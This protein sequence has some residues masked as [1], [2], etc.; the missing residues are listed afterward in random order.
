MEKMAPFA[1]AFCEVVC[2][3][4]LL[5]TVVSM[6]RKSAIYVM[7]ISWRLMPIMRERLRPRTLVSY[8]LPEEVIDLTNE[9]DQEERADHSRAKFDKTEN[10]SCKELLVLSGNTHE[11]EVLR[12]ILEQLVTEIASWMHT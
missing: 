7:A 3:I 12:S 8:R 9:I 11:C 6:T 10:A 5:A 1:A 4:F 2:C